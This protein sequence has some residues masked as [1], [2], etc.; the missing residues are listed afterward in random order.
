MT[1]ELKSNCMDLDA[2][3]ILLFLKRRGYV[4]RLFQVGK[5]LSGRGTESWLRKKD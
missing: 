3:L 2:E 5:F 4:D 1:K